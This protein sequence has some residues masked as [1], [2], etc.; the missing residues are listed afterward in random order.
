MFKQADRGREFEREWQGRFGR[1]AQ[2]N[3][4]DHLISGWSESGLLRRLA[5]FEELIGLHKIIVPSRILDLGCGAGS[6]V[7]YLTGHGHEVVGLDYSL[8]CLH[9]ALDADP[10]R[11]GLYVGGEAYHLPF[12]NE[13]FDLVTSIGV[14]QALKDPERALDEMVRVL[15]PGGL[16]V[17][18]FLNAFEIIALL[19]AL[20][21]KMSGRM[22]RL[23]TYSPLEVRRWFDRRGLKIFQQ[24]GIY[25]PPRRLPQIGQVLNHKAVVRLI[26]MIPGLSMTGAHAFLLAGIKEVV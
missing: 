22:P 6:Y 1:F 24:L 18:E 11:N 8:P 21:E 20:R 16:L 14:L 10:K 3:S 13:C 2:E 12:Y 19:K 4:A 5:V 25:L 23:C 9:R 26:E 7:R 17:V 15:H